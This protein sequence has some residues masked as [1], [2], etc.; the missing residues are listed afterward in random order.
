MSKVLVVEDEEA[1][2]TVYCMIV[3]SAGF[4]VAQAS[5]GAEGLKQLKAFKPDLVLLDMLM[6]IKTGLEFLQAANIKK[7]YPKTTVIILSNLSESPT[8]QEALKLGAVRHLIKSNIM[9]DDLL[10]IVK[11]HTA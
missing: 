3:E 10:A 8:I 4:E 7:R 11:S 5:D 2:R 1:L 6:P 9:P